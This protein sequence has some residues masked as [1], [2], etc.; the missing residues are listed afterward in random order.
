MNPHYTLVARRAA[1][2]CE[3]CH[4]PEVIFNFP[5]EV[6]HII[7]LSKAGEDNKANLALACRACN[8]HKGDW[9]TGLDEQTR[10]DSRLFNPR[11]DNWEE[12]FMLDLETGTIHGLTAIG[13]ASVW[14][15]RMNKPMQVTARLRWIQLGF[16]I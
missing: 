16:F 1:H 10:S 5:F 3:Y 12:H 4:A 8:V 7:P 2:R 6:E 9:L 11:G 15:L 14:R 13:R